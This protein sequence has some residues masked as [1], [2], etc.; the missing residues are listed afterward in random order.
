VLAVAFDPG[1]NIIATAPPNGSVQFWRFREGAFAKLAD[2]P[3]SHSEFSRKDQ[4]IRSMMFGKTKEELFV[5]ASGSDYR[6]QV[7]RI[8]VPANS[9]ESFGFAPAKDQFLK[10]VAGPR[11][12]GGQLMAT[13]LYSR[14]SVNYPA[15]WGFASAL[16]EPIC[17]QGTT[18]LSKFDLTGSKLLT[19]SG[20]IWLTPDTVQ[21]WDV[22]MRIKGEAVGEFHA[23]GKPAPPWLADLARAVSGIP[24]VS[25]SD[26]NAP[27]LSDVFE[28]NASMAP[29]ALYSPYDMVRKHFF[30]AQ[31]SE[32]LRNAETATPAPSVP[33]G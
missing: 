6:V 4:R 25:D 21:I 18:A 32:G 26:D 9:V 14:V 8:N 16:A 2:T 13:S 31:A 23:D 27:L 29:G 11:T 10:L 1:S 20:S 17:F 30:P 7:E 5:V 19:L 12:S 15:A 3:T 22:S 33:S 28:Q 24:R